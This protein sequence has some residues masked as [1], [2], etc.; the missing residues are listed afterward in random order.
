MR[1]TWL[2]EVLRNAGLEV[3]EVDGWQGRG[4]SFSRPI[5]GI[6]HPHTATSA[7]A[8]GDYPSLG[9]VRDGRSDLPRPL[10]QLGLGRSGT[11]YV[12]AAGIANH[13]GVGHWPG[14]LGNYD[15]IGIEA[16]HPGTTSHPWPTVQLAAC[17]RSAAAL[18]AH[19]GLPTDRIIGYEEWAPGR[20]I[21]PIAV[22]LHAVRRSI[23]AIRGERH[24]ADH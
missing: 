20:K 2:P 7:T 12:I 22:D 4:R 21:D 14:I 24:M 1:L 18:S 6:V 8:K 10:A 23:A 9:V 19:L 16:E 17:Y 3:I 13:A 11:V 5:A 15:T